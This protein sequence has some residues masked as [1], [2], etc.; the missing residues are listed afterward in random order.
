MSDFYVYYVYF[1]IN[2][3]SME[4]S[5]KR[6]KKFDNVFCCSAPSLSSRQFFDLGEWNEL[7]SQ[8][9]VTCKRERGEGEREACVCVCVWERERER[10]NVGIEY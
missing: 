3:D 10:D 4:C 9:V 6:H 5:D 2:I 1:S 8:H 7:W